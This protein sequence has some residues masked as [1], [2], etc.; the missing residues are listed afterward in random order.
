MLTYKQNW[1]ILI[2]ILIAVFLIVG[3]IIGIM[4]KS[5]KIWI[6]SLILLIIYLLAFIIN[7]F[8]FFYGASMLTDYFK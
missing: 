4:G 8:I 3:T 2:V 1:L 6:T 5:K 7:P